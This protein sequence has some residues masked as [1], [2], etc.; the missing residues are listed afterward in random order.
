MRKYASLILTACIV[1]CP[2]HAIEKDGRFTILSMGTKSCGDVVKDFKEDGRG[3]MDNSI[4]VAGYLTAI[5]ERVAK[6]SNV[7][8]G[9]DPESWDL[10]INNYCAARPLE[11]LS[12]AATSLVAE[13]S[14]RA[15]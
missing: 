6:R 1:A 8:S 12:S 13:L 4:W 14:K 5:N 2:C 11:T 3:K 9:T 7:A 15:K 10:W